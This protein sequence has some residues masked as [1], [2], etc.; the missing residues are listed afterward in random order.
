MAITNVG[1]KFIQNGYVGLYFDGDAGP[2]SNQN[3]A[4]DDNTGHLLTA[5]L[6]HR[7]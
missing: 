3:A 6:H 2:R 7:Q 5:R 1:D 4:Q